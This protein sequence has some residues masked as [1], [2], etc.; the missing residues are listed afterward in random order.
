M[1]GKSTPP[2]PGRYE[3]PRDNLIRLW[4]P[5]SE[6]EL[7]IPGIELR[8]K[9]GSGDG[10]TPVM[11]GHFC[12]FNRWTEIDSWFEGNFMERIA[13]GAAKK[14]F[15]ENRTGMKVLFQHGRDPQIG[16]KPL[17]PIRS[18]AEDNTGGAYEVDLLDADYVRSTL[19]PG[20]EAGLYGAS[21]RFSIIKEDWNQ[22]PPRSEHNPNGI[23]E[24]TI[25]EMRVSEFG[26]VTFPAY[27]D[28]TA[29]LRS[30]TDEY[31]AA[32]LG[33][34][35]PEMLRMAGEGATLADLIARKV[36]PEREQPREHITVS[37]QRADEKAD[38]EDGAAETSP[39]EK[40]TPEGAREATPE[41]PDATADEP[42]ER[43]SG[44]SEEGADTPA[45]T[46][47]G[48]K[49]FVPAWQREH[50]PL[51]GKEDIVEGP[52]PRRERRERPDYLEAPGSAPTPLRG[53]TKEPW[54][55]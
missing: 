10:D 24:R 29:G 13:P 54:R 53:N 18:L 1:S 48:D 51:P 46:P 16:S 11:A 39:A 5:P 43:A 36:S 27:P 28:A 31:I 55:L 17:G 20:L 22:E 49:D 15:K 14:T 45:D 44:E 21:F 40:E 33:L 50:P 37:T 8:A 34:G 47:A 4:S 38:P 19:L 3:A 9:N 25:K 35:D 52:Q 2:P 30:L 42:A 23:P 41:A 7:T 6:G 26:P 32:G 12:V